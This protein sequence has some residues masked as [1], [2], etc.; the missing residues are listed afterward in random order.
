MDQQG[1]RDILSGRDARAYA[2]L[3]RSGLSVAAAPYEWA[4]WL[5]RWEYRLGVLRSRRAAAPVIS[6]GN[7]T[8]GG[9]GKTPMVAWVVAQLRHAG[10]NPAIL[11]RGYKAHA[12]RSDEAE[13]LEKL[14]GSAVFINPDRLAAAGRAVAGGA[15]VLVMDDGFQ[16]RKLKRNL[17]VVLIDATQPFGF[18]H[19][20]PRGLLREPVSALRCAEV[21]VVTRSDAVAGD[22]LDSLLASIEGIAGRAPICL[23]VHRPKSILD[24]AGRE[25]PLKELS[26]RKVCAL[27][28]I[29]NPESFFETLTSLGARIVWRRVLD[30]HTVY[31]N[32]L[33]GMLR[34]EI[35]PG[36]ADVLVT[37]QKDAVK[38]EGVSL[39]RPIWQLAVEIDIVRGRDELIGKVLSAADELPIADSSEQT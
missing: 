25:M 23:A 9:T 16:H 15:D 18:G 14:T 29:A 21:I 2:V 38:L 20:L 7:I 6:V 36:E 12:G 10:K 31:T 17:D 8:T 28:G 19:C 33:V 3:L 13:L 1:I 24:E 30:D 34:E 32:R 22:E 26:G 4:M 35:Q 11:T 27:C 37:T 5:R 39:G